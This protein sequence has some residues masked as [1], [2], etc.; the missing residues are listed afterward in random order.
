M[1]LSVRFIVF[2][3]GTI[4]QREKQCKTEI[5]QASGAGTAARNDEVNVHIFEENS[6]CF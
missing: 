4:Q 3:T 6:T 1:P 2:P 5:K